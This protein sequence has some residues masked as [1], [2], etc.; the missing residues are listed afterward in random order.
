VER[1]HSRSAAGLGDRELAEFYDARYEGDYMAQQPPLE[2]GRVEELLH[3]VR[4]PVRTVLDFGCG[5]GGWVPVLERVFPGARLTG[6]D[7]SATAIARATADLPRH[8]FERF[9]GER[10]PGED[11]S[12]D[13][14][15]SYHVLEHVLDL[16]GSAAEIARLVAPGGQACVI[17]PCGNPG[18]LE[19]RIVRLGDGGVDAETGRFFFEDP[20]HL[21][22]MTSAEATALFERHGLSL[23][24]PWFANQLWGAVHFLALAGSSVTGELCRPERASSPAGRARLRALRLLVAALTPFVQAWSLHRPVDRIRRARGASERLRGS[25]AALAKLLAAPVGAAL[26]RLARREW[27]RRREQPNGSAQ[28]LLFEKL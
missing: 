14:V 13:L 22:R 25:G 10:A 18:S 27:E 8:R 26:E 4:A 5:R 16:E 2:V 9:D 1:T 17:F 6:V 24:R 21:R 12:Y 28:Y 20:G 15:F 23:V 11:G 3:E 7:I 19:E